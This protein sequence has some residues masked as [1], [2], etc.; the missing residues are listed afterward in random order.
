MCANRLKRWLTRCKDWIARARLAGWAWVR[1]VI[2]IR[3]S[4]AP[5]GVLFL[6]FSLLLLATEPP[7]KA[8]VLWF[9][10]PS[11]PLWVFTISGAIALAISF[12][13]MVA[14]FYRWLGN[15]LKK[16][17]KK[18]LKVLYWVIFFIVSS[19]SSLRALSLVPKENDVFPFALV[20]VLIWF[21]VIT[22]VFF[23]IIVSDTVKKKASVS[24][25]GKES[26]GRKSD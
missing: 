4:M 22:F 5:N 9:E 23:W 18:Q 10:A 19:I 24:T 20:L 3:D 13:F 25:S 15:Q 11:L 26:S 14:V 6:S 7:E 21:F 1:R 16:L 12:V 17:L 8:T 2:R